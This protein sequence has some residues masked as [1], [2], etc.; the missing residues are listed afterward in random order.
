MCATYRPST[1]KTIFGIAISY[2]LC[3]SACIGF[4]QVPI[5]TEPAPVVA[6][7]P[8]QVASSLKSSTTVG[9]AGYSSSFEK[10]MA[11]QVDSHLRGLYLSVK[12]VD[13]KLVDA[14]IS[15]LKTNLYGKSVESAANKLCEELK[16]DFI[17]FGTINEISLTASTGG[18]YNHSLAGNVRIYSRKQKAIVVSTSIQGTSAVVLNPEKTQIVRSLSPTVSAA[19]SFADNWGT[20]FTATAAATRR[21]T[22]SFRVNHSEL[23][24]ARVGDSYAIYQLIRENGKIVHKLV[25]KGLLTE[26]LSNY[27]IV[28]VR[29]GFISQPSKQY[30]QFVAERE[31]RAK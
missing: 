12:T 18:R 16:A 2:A 15:K 21:D 3:C 11:S 9:V 8:F 14:A 19:S 23:H 31:S 6:V 29:N 22:T 24:G 13:S 7:A 28:T 1:S 4:A 26:A 30:V 10:E 17:A 20:Y 5:S 25:A 27:S